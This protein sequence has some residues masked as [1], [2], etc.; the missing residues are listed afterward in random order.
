MTKKKQPKKKLKPAPA[1]LVKRQIAPALA[2]VKH[3]A[4]VF[5]VNAE[6]I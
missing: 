1:K 3:F 6:V 2:K 4:V 5:L